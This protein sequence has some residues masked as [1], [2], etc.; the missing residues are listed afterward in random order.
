MRKYLIHKHNRGQA[1]G[2]VAVFGAI[3]IF[4]IGATIRTAI[5]TSYTQNQQLKTMRIALLKSLEG[6]NAG[7]SSRNTTSITYVEDRLSPDFGKYGALDRTPFVSSASGTFTNLLFYPVDEADLPNAMPIMDVYIN[8]QHF[9]FTMAGVS[10]KQLLPPLQP[11][12]TSVRFNTVY[13]AA[14]VPDPA[15][16]GNY[17]Y[18]GWDF[19]CIQDTKA[20]VYYGCQLLYHIV[21]NGTQGFCT[22]D[23]CGSGVL[24]ADERFDL[25]RNDK[26]DLKDDPRPDTKTMIPRESMSWQWDAIRGLTSADKKTYPLDKEMD[27]ENGKYALYDIDGDKQEETVYSYTG[28]A[29]GVITSIEVLDNQDGDVSFTTDDNLRPGSL[30][31]RPETAI[32]TRTN[33][34]DGINSM[35]TTGTFLLIKEGKGP[36]GAYNPEN[37]T[38]VRSQN[39]KDQVD[40]VERQFYLS[41]DT[42]RFCSIEPPSSTPAGSPLPLPAATPQALVDGE[43]NPVEACGTGR[44]CMDG[45]KLPLIDGKTNPLTRDC[46]DCFSR[47]NV[48]KTCFDTVWV[49]VPGFTTKQKR[50]VIYIRSRILDQRGHKWITD[51]T[52]RRTNLNLRQ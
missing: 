2:E 50:Y 47:E 8:G 34:P 13:P 16:N 33:V 49:D 18:K 43:P 35:A 28:D 11:R 52:D 39:K 20:N 15:G 46:E 22:T 19:K 27:V 24:S 6:S 44:F 37:G 26:Y 38:F 1:A 5:S 23:F 32:Y 12:S 42:G 4:L 7:N 30:G 29:H 36:G 3:I 31:L 10:T 40:V 45:Q 21:A 14:S 9:P 17:H 41:N 25:N 51:V 48:D